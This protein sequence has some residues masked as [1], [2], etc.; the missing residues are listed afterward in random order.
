MSPG[1]TGQG[2]WR[3]DFS[4]NVT[5]LHLHPPVAEAWECLGDK[6]PSGT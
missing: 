1:H 2:S 5:E 4:V 6:T 3:Q